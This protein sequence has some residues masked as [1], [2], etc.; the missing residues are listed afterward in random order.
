MAMVFCNDIPGK[1]L[2]LR[3]ALR[4]QIHDQ[5]SLANCD[6]DRLVHSGLEPSNSSVNRKLPNESKEATKQKRKKNIGVTPDEEA[7]LPPSPATCTDLHS[8]RL[9]PGL[10]ILVDACS[11]GKTVLTGG[12]LC[13]KTP[14]I[15]THPPT[16]KYDLLY[17]HNF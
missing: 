11:Q 7:V 16:H 6:C 2:F 10:Q 4:V 12:P 15:L 1:S 3:R 14:A 9:P 8:V 13:K 5:K 17:K